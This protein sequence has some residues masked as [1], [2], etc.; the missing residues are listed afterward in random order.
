MSKSVEPISA[1]N[2]NKTIIAPA[3][4]LPSKFAYLL[5]KKIK[6]L[7]DVKVSDNVC[8]SHR[9]H[10]MGICNDVSVRRRI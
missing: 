8:D 6:E 10:N 7:D 3:V 1:I 5:H 9:H 4:E 2:D